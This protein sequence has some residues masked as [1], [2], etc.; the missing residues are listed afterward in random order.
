VID[1]NSNG[2]GEYGFFAELAGAVAVRGS[3]TVMID[4]PNLSTAFGN[5]NAQSCVARSGYLFCMFLPTA[6][7]AAASRRLPSVRARHSRG[8]P[9]LGRDT[10]VLLRVAAGLRQLGQ[11]HV[12]HLPER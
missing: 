8:R 1:A 6:A 3:A 9:Q 4:P 11:A 12:L 2:M 10:V 7:L 5:I